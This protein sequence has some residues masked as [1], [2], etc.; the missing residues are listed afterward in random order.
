[1]ENYGQVLEYMQKYLM[2][3]IYREQRVNKPLTQ[4]PFLK[5]FF[6][7]LFTSHFQKRDGGRG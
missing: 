5:T 7:Y 3:P 4:N 6:H 1:M 2:E